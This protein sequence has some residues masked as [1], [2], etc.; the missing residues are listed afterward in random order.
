V[1][2]AAGASV[3]LLLPTIL[4]IEDGP[5]AI[6]VILSPHLA[7]ASVALLPVAGF[8]R[9][10]N[11]AIALAIVAVLCMYRFGAEWWSPPVVLGDATATIDVA[12]WNVEAGTQAIPAILA[13][14][15]RHPVDVLAIEELTPDVAAAIEADPQLAARYPYRALFPTPGVAGIGLFSAFPIRTASNDL[16]PVRVEAELDVNGQAIFVVAAHPFPARISRLAGIPSGLDPAKRNAELELLRQR[17]LELDVEHDRV[18][19]IGDFN[20]APTEPAFQ[21]LTSGLHDAHAD[22]GIGPGWSWRPARF[23]FVGVGLLRIDLIL[24]S[25]ALMPVSTSVDCPSTGD[26]CLVE[27]T[28]RFAN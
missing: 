16:H 4:P 12:T 18:L 17:V 24:S 20:T 25:S 11:L 28:L 8:A 3:L 27:A 15:N 26:H 1:A 22:V 9:S 6:A 21:R 7:L 5:L 13:L 14:L 10:R 23:A 2:Y 19:L